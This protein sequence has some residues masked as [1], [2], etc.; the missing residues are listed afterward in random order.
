LGEQVLGDLVVVVQ[1]EQL[2]PLIAQ[3]GDSGVL[4]GV[5]ERSRTSLLGER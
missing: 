4:S 2:E 1:P 3:L 5:M